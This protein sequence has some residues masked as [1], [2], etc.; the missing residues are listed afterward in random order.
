MRPIHIY[1]FTGLVFAIA[2][3]LIEGHTTVA[4]VLCGFGAITGFVQSFNESKHD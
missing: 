2:G 1:G 3:T 4:T